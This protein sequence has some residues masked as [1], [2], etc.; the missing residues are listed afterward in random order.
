L[1]IVN[2]TGTEQINFKPELAADPWTG[3]G[4]EMKTVTAT[5]TRRRVKDVI[6]QPVVNPLSASP[7]RR[8]RFLF[9]P[10]GGT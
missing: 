7:R 9:R 5:W 1:E 6:V 2:P 10:L 4:E 3:F 8:E